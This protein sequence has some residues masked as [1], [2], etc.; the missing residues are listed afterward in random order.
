MAATVG[1]EDDALEG[2]GAET[3][4]KAQDNEL[5]IGDA[6]SE[7][8]ASVVDD[9]GVYEEDDGVNE[10]GADTDLSDS[11]PVLSALE[12]RANAPSRVPRVQYAEGKVLRRVSD[13]RLKSWL[14]AS[15]TPKFG[16]YG[17]G[18]RSS[19]FVDRAPVCMQEEAAVGSSSSSDEDARVSVVKR[20]QRTELNPTM[21]K[22]FKTEEGAAEWTPLI[23]KELTTLGPKNSFAI[24][25]VWRS[26]IPQVAEILMLQPELT[27]KKSTGEKKARLVVN[28]KQESVK[29]GENN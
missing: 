1:D 23:V 21:V 7:D 8:E 24:E 17:F 6:E 25:Q 13:R 14:L 5:Y 26:S 11:R 27:T 28:G 9:G 12:E 15:T 4:V 22:A 19:V 10:G 2:G 18:S 29:E 20:K 16:D 3:L